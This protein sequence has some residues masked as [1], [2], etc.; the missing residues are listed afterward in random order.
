MSK[1]SD[2]DLTTPI[3]VISLKDS[4]ERQNHLKMQLDCLG[5]KYSVFSAVDG[6]LLSTDEIKEAYDGAKALSIRGKHLGPREIGVALSHISLCQE[7]VDHQLEAMLVL[8]DDVKIDP[9]VQSVVKQAAQFPSD[10]DVVFLGCDSRRV[11]LKSVPGGTVFSD[12]FELTQ[13]RGTGPVKGAYAYMISYSGA[14]K[15]L[16]STAK[17]CK[18]IDSYTGDNRVLN[19]YVFRPNIISHPNSFPS[20]TSLKLQKLL[21]LQNAR[22]IAGEESEHYYKLHKPDLCTMTAAFRKLKSSVEY[23]LVKLCLTVF[24]RLDSKFR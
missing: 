9:A 17:F 15:L 6:D 10:W 11:F 2:L 22:A 3:R 23:R 19:I 14:K 24:D 21:R 13:A 16:E 5:L 1:V 20:I 12:G 18:P 4:L 8:E 7:V